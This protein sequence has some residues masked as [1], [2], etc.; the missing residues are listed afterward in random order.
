MAGGQLA[1][2]NFTPGPTGILSSGG[3]SQPWSPLNSPQPNFAEYAFVTATPFAISVGGETAFGFTY[4]RNNPAPGVIGDPGSHSDLN[5]DFDTIGTPQLGGP[6]LVMQGVYT[7]MTGAVCDKGIGA[8]C[9]ISS[10]VSADDAFVESWTLLG[11]QHTNQL[12]IQPGTPA[13]P[14]CPGG[15]TAINCTVS[16]IDLFGF[17]TNSVVHTD[18]D[19]DVRG[20]NDFCS[21]CLDGFAFLNDG[22]QGIFTN[23]H[24]TF[25]PEPST[26]FV[27]GGILALVLAKARRRRA[28]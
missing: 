21:S 11:V 9:T 5:I 6:A 27:A 12:A 23:I 18:T 28:S 25:T 17:A 20:L 22:R 1:F 2:G 7:E 13:D 26:L 15:P 10:N 14:N 19:I 3:S 8:P 16:K 24:P 4:T